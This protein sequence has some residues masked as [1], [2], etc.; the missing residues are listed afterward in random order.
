MAPKNIVYVVDDDEAA[1]DS[2]ATLLISAGLRTKTFASGQQFLWEAT[3]L[4]PGC[5]VSDI[6]ML[7]MEGITLLHQLK[8]LNLSFPVVLL[9][10]YGDIKMAVQ[11]IKSGAVDF[12]EKPYD[13]E[14]ILAAVRRAQKE[15]NEGQESTTLAN[16]ATER[17]NSLSAREREVFERLVAGLTNK[18]I[19]RDLNISP[20]TVE[21]H[22]SHVMAKMQARGISELV[23]LALLAG[24]RIDP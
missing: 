15:W 9:T 16:I 22:R 12:I 13:D 20:R 18:K 14:T 7:E 1:R 5:L 19:A 6:R 10:G 11:A 3:S 21:F 2:L 8:A 17:L 4:E 23:R 24:L